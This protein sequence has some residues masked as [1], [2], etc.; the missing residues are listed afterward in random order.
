MNKLF[1]LLALLLPLGLVAAP[2]TPVPTEI[3]SDLFES[4]STDA[5]THAI[6]SG[7]VIVTGTNLRLTCDRVE[8]F[9]TGT[10]DLTTGENKLDSIKSLVATGKVRIVQGEREA[11]C[12]RAEVYPREGKLILTQNPT[13]IDHASGAVAVGEPITLLRGDR[14]VYG[15]NLR[16]T[17]PAIRDLGYEKSKEATLAPSPAP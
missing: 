8:I 3:R 5:E 7:N 4:T 10:K 14:K 6:F 1:L 9:A 2:A 13:V 11:T 12:G 17:L 16:V 15:E